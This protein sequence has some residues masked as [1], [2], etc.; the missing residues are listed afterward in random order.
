[1]YLDAQID[2]LL[3]LQNLRISTHNFFTP[4]FS[5]ITGFGEYFIPITFC[6][7]LYWNIDKKQGTQILLSA[8]LTMMFCSLLKNIF[9][10]YRPW[11]LD[12]HIKPVESALRFATGYSFPSGHSSLAVSC[13]GSVALLNS[14][15]KKI[16][17]SMIILCL[18][19]AF[20]RIY[21]GVHTPQDIITGLLVGTLGIFVVN[22]ALN[23]IK[24]NPQYDASVNVVITIIGFII[25]TYTYFKE[26]PIDY[27]LQGEILVNSERS[28]MACF[29]KFGFLV[30]ALWGGYIERRFINFN[31][32]QE[33][34]KSKVLLTILGIVILTV[35]SAY[36]ANVWKSFFN[37]AISNFI[38]ML[39]ISLFITCIYPF[40]IKK[41]TC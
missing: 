31:F 12:T 37:H 30:G 2:F 3:F 23:Y 27:N 32:T 5:L 11:I 1:M 13:W 7:I 25:L 6:A 41:T 19:V 15:N 40:C 36:T 9:C 38:N 18:L 28:R 10:I 16:L 21:L 17:W 14:H 8:S 29:P 20:S 39:I 4:F 26:Y 35:I 22:K 33:T 24:E 34:I